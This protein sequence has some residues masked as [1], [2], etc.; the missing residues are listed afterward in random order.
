MRDT[1]AWLRGYIYRVT[2]RL[3]RRNIEIGPGLRIYKRLS[4]VGTGKVILGKNC[5]IGEALG[6]RSQFVTLYTHDESAI[7]RIG[8][9]AA[10]YAARVSSKYEISIGDDVLIEQS[11]LLDTD[12]H[13]IERSRKNPEDETR[14]RCR[15]VVGDRVSIGARSFVTKGVK[16][17]DDVLV[18]PGSVVTSLIKAGSCVG[19]NPAKPIIGNSGPHLTGS[20]SA[21][22]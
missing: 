6:D 19:G 20:K 2:C 5:L 12:F 9:G 8:D 16:I 4:I 10:L 11:G 15:I 1:L 13:S 7:I 14:E 21:L 17:E 22:G 18:I 3:F